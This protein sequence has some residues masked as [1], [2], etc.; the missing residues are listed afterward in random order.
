MQIRCKP[1]KFSSEQKK[2]IFIESVTA[3]NIAE[4]CRRHG[5][6]V[7]LFHRW[8]ERSGEPSRGNEYQKD[9]DDL[10]GLVADQALALDALKKSTGEEMTI[11]RISRTMEIPI[12]TIYYQSV[13]SSSPNDDPTMIQGEC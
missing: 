13:K 11:A 7:T 1:E 9:I 6:T 4:L 8:K 5:V 10:N 2:Q 12:S 3:T